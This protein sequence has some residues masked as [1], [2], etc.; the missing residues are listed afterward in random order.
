[1]IKD[2]YIM[3]LQIKKIYLQNWKCYDNQIIE[4]NLNTEHNIWIIS[5]L[6]GYGKTSI[7]EA[8]LWCLYGN[9]IVSPKKLIKAEVD[10]REQLPEKQGYFHYPNVKLNP[11]LELSVSLTLQNE[12]HN[13]LI[14]RTAK[15]VKRGNSFRAEV[16]EASFNL[17]GKLKTDSRERIDLLLPRSCKEFFFFDGEKIKEYSSVTQTEETRKAIESILGIPEII[18]LK[19][20]T[21]NVVAKV[22]Q[23]I[24][25]SN[26]DNKQLQAIDT[27]LFELNNKIVT[28]KD[29]IQTAIQEY[30]NELKILEDTNERANQIKELKD[31]L[32]RLKELDREKQSLEQKREKIEKDI[33]KVMK[34]AAIP[35]MSNFIKEVASDLQ[36]QT[37][38]NTRMSISVNQLKELLEADICVCGRC[39]DK[40][41]SEYIT[42]QL[43]NI[44][45]SGILQAESSHI[46][47]LRIQLKGLSSYKISNL[48][49]LLLERDRIEDDMEE[50]KQVTESL[51]KDTQGVSEME[52]NEIW[53]KV[54]QQERIVKEAE[55]T[56]QRLRNQIESLQQQQDELTRQRGKLLNSDREKAVLQ[57][58]YELAEG[59]NKATDELIDWFTKNCQ[60][61][62]ENHA[63]RL[64][65][66]VTNKPEE[67]KGVVLKDGYNLRIKQTNG[68]II[69]PES[70][71]EGEKEALVFTFIAGL[72][73]ASV[74]LLPRLKHVG[75]E[76]QTEI[77][78]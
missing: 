39:I 46:E 45:N 65:N 13:Y 12:T 47:S 68:D 26:L 50:I 34:V 1:M 40:Q 78:T 5:G 15:R 76:A 70:L 28:Q 6:N 21:K 60:Q 53:R 33:S 3:T 38:T 4:F 54:G 14:S 51:K 32:D 42:Q 30:K 72:N 48:D 41:A 52:A 61:T 35:L 17:D 69:N 56:I 7:L 2:G 10:L 19:T 43:E 49:D 73:L 59:L 64:H 22:E 31:K 77:A 71:S 58:Q 11:E 23:K 36:I 55:A 18:N 67:Y 29:T 66:L 9:E 74:D 16:P 44:E 37:M 57:K 8:V 63:S 25:Q 24:N 27:K 62:I 20:D 75:F